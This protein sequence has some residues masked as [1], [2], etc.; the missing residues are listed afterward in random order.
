MID[1][2]NKALKGVDLNKLLEEIKTKNEILHTMI[3]DITKGGKL[4]TS[5]KSING[6]INEIGFLQKV[7]ALKI[8]TL[9]TALE[10]A[11]LEISP[12]EILAIVKEIK[13]KYLK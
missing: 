4:T 6:M 2:I 10:E 12:N 7:A 8:A 9:N 11:L 5:I 1:Q 13:E 3:S